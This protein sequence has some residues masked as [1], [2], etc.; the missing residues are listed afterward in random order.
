MYFS[1]VIEIDP[2]QMTLI[3]RVKPTKLFGKLLDALSLGQLS[4]KQEH[5]TFTALSILQ[6][7]NMGL[8]SMNI[9]N[10]IRLAVDDYDFYLDEKGVEDDL[11]DAMFEL[12]A[13]IDP[14]E[15]EIFNTVYLVLEH[16]EDSLK[17]IIEISVQRKHR[18][19]EY[20][21]KITINSV[22]AEFKQQDNET[23]QQLQE[24]MMSVFN[25]QAKYDEYIS[26]NK[27]K[28]DAFIDK[29]ELGIRK[30]IKVDDI[31]KHTE[32]QM[33]RPKHLIADKSHI[34]YNPQGQPI[35][36]GYYG[37]SDYFLYSMIWAQTCLYNDI[38]CHD[39]TL[40]D[41]MGNDLM[42]VGNLGFNAG[43]TNTLNPD[44]PFEAPNTGEIVF[45]GENE[46]ADIL[47]EEHLLGSIEP[48]PVEIVSD[49]WLD[50]DSV[51]VDSGGCGSCSSSCG[52]CNN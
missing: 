45:Y 38:Y 8:R 5:E 20:P 36:Y 40:V 37:M 3:K 12:K 30:V 27:A 35:Y 24:R 48:E 34:K 52:S 50:S 43:E 33:I 41:D 15:S 49:G 7:L 14:L 2:S 28:F 22:L 19:G 4:Q 13:K 29:L 11:S 17:S 21:I 51:D 46:Y 6:Q 26:F 10:V 16:L 39:F 47:S 1:G 18:V 42:T 32:C 25:S 44:A 31:L 23:V 9:K